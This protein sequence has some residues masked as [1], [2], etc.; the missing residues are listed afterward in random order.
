MTNLARRFL[1]SAQEH[2]KAFDKYY[3]APIEKISARLPPIG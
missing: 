1:L 3:E 2:L